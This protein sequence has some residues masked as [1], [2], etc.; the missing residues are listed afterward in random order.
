MAL[1]GGQ[2]T[3]VVP[4]VPGGHRLLGH[5]VEFGRDPLA[6]LQRV[7]GHGDVVRIRAVADDLGTDKDDQFGT[8][9]LLVLMREGVAH[10]GNLIEFVQ[11]PEMWS[12]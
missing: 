3:R 12:P 11:A 6:L 8:G 9:A 5:A 7:R 1:L 10:A 2:A 4:L